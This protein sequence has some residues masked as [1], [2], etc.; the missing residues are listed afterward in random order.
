MEFFRAMR[1]NL[2]RPIMGLE[3]EFKFFNRFKGGVCTGRNIFGADRLEGVA[4]LSA[5]HRA[6]PA[7]LMRSTTH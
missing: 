3:R 2:C 4:K 7:G 6:A 5:I 1:A